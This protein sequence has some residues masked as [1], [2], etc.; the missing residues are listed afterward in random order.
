MSIDREHDSIEIVNRIGLRAGLSGDDAIG[1]LDQEGG[2]AF[3]P[4]ELD[5]RPAVQRPSNQVLPT[6]KI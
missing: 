5:S 6:E 4:K 1:M 2:R 3:K